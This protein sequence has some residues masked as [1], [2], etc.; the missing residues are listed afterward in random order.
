MN[1]ENKMSL[2]FYTIGAVAGIISGVL[3]TQAQMGYLAG[4]LIYLVSPKI[5]MAVVKDLPEELKDDRILLRKGMWGF[6][7][8]W[9]YFT[10]FSYNL[11]IQPEPK[12]Y[13]NQSL[14]YNI[15][16]G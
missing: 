8:F 16:K 2:I 14:L 5:V 10:L 13:S 12:F 4:L 3:S 7:L 9:L 6:L 15:T 1:V 11:I